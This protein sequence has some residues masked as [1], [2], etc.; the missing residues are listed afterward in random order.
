MTTNTAT[1]TPTGRHHVRLEYPARHYSVDFEWTLRWRD[2]NTSQLK[3]IYVISFEQIW[4]DGYLFIDGI[5]Y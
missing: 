2:H 4:F 3:G 1:S 5:Y